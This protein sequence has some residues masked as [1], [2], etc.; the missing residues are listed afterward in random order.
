MIDYLFRDNLSYFWEIT[1]IIP[2]GKICY[3]KGVQTPGLER[4]TKCVALLMLLNS[5]LVQDN[6]TK[7]TS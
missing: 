4:R 6:F 5:L 1:E 3:Q 7:M 2:R